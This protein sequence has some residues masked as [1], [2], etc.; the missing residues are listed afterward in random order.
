MA[1]DDIFVSCG[2]C[3]VCPYH[4]TIGNRENWCSD[5]SSYIDSIMASIVLLVVE[6]IASHIGGEVGIVENRRCLRDIRRISEGQ[7]IVEGN[8][9][10]VTD[11]DIFESF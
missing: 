4:D 9:Y 11:R 2:I 1:N 8:G 6:S 7:C 5:G 3:F 10:I